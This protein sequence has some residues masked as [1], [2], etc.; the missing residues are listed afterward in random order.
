MTKSYADHLGLAIDQ[1]HVESVLTG[2]GKKIQTVGSTTA[3]YRFKHDPGVFALRFEILSDCVHDLILGKPFL[4]ATETF[5]S[6]ANRARRVVRRIAS[7]VTQHHALFLGDSAP[8]FSG[9][10]NGQSQEALADSGCKVLLIDEDYAKQLGLPILRRNEYRVKLIFA[11]N[12]IAMSSGIVKGLRWTFGINGDEQEHFLDFHVLKNAP[13]PVILSEKLLFDT[14]AFSRYA[15][16]L[17]DADEEDDDAYF[18]AID[19]DINYRH[20]G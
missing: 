15:C 7:K 2:S 17:E 4:K 10:L 20:E 12:S 6:A 16:Y 18:L 11:D 1:T 14:E 5:S 8:R 9:T 19:I 3:R 13:A